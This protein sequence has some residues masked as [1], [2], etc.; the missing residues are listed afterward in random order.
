MKKKAVFLGASNTYGVGLSLFRDYYLDSKN[1][2]ST[3]PYPNPTHEDYQF[4][5][6]NR[7]SHLLS[8][9]LGTS[10]V[11]VSEAGGSPAE[12]LYLLNKMNLDEIEYVIFEF[13]SPY[14][15]FDRYFYQGSDPSDPIPRTPKEIES[16]LTNGKNDRPELR[17]KIYKWL[18]T[19]N[20]EEFTN[21]VFSSIKKFISKNKHIK[22]VILFWRNYNI[23]LSS[24]DFK[25]MLNYVPK[26][27]LDRNKENIF[28]ETLLEE[29][30]MRVCDEFIHIDKIKYTNGIRDRHPS[31]NGH[32]KIFEILQNYID[33]KNSTDSW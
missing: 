27:P 19:F 15:F 14:S 2:D 6:Q 3:H 4:I 26:F 20:P 10:E 23:N 17:E 9:Y 22:F 32:R 30:K 5:C 29:N 7:F 12:S 31:L 8:E 13:S 11:N 18:D 28:V 25:W 1:V 21:E 24:D 33:E 16:F